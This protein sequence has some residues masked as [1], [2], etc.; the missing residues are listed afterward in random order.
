MLRPLLIA[1]VATALLAPPA[2]AQEISA[3]AAPAAPAAGDPVSGKGLFDLRCG[4]CHAAAEGVSKPMAPN[5]WQVFGRK[6]ASDPNFRYSQAMQASGLTWD[7]AT[8]DVYLT[9][10]TAK[11]PGSMMPLPTPD[12]AQRA[13]IIAYLQTLH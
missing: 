7:A 8:L 3:P 13:D 12:P 2:L 1:A 6:A 10:P 9:S 5:L 11:V 4:L